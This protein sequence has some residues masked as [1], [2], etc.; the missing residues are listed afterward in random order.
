MNTIVPYPLS[1]LPL[2]F[3]LGRYF[4]QTNK[5]AR[6]KQTLTHHFPL[7]RSNQEKEESA[8]KMGSLAKKG[9]NNYVKQLQQHPLRT[10]VPLL[11]H[12]SL[13]ISFT[14][15][16]LAFLLAWPLVFGSAKRVT[17]SG[18]G[19]KLCWWV[20]L[21]SIH[22]LFLIHLANLTYTVTSF[23]PCFIVGG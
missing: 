2:L 1:F 14:F 7:F 6:L 15:T 23:F 11:L 16:W 5:H 13:S 19:N 10:K 22:Q 12:L 18:S 4:C 3:F 17:F 8:P 20:Y 21:D 9:L